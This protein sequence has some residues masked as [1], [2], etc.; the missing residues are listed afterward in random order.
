MTTPTFEVNLDGEVVCPHRNLSCCP[1]CFAATP[2]LIDVFGVVYR[3]DPAEWAGATFAPETV[4]SPG[5][6]R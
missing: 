4:L 1:A 5:T 6:T 2:G 3:Y